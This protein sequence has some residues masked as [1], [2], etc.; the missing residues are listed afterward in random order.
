MAFDWL[1][2]VSSTLAVLPAGLAL[3][4]GYSRYDGF[5]RD[6]VIFLFFV[7]GLIAGMGVA[8]F[9]AALALA[10]GIAFVLGIPLL[11]QFAKTIIVNR[12]KWQG[13]GHAVFNGGTYGAG[14]GVILSLYYFQRYPPGWDL[15]ATLQLVGVT[16]GITFLNVAMGW[17]IGAAVRDRA[18]FKGTL[19][20]AVAALPMTYLL[21]YWLNFFDA[22]VPALMAAYGAALLAFGLAK[23]LPGALTPTEQQDLR[24]KKRKAMR[25]GS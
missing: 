13:E 8:F 3:L 15:G 19:F 14:M 6:N 7:G 1:S 16:V 5:F 12:R 4:W 20:A 23:V 21:F 11:E 18:P 24:R 2:I 25:E 17:T 10:G 22:W 9:H